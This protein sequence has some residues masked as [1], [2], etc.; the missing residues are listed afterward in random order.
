MDHFWIRLEHH[1]RDLTCILHSRSFTFSASAVP[2]QHHRDCGLE[3]AADQTLE[4][5]T[6]ADAEVWLRSRNWI[7]DL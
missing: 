2:R 4:P 6:I 7:F 5:R 1:L 3:G